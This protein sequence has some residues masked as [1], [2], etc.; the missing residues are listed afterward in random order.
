MCYSL[1]GNVFHT[2]TYPGILNVSIS[3]SMQVATEQVFVANLSTTIIVT[4][5]TPF[6]S[7]VVYITAFNSVGNVMSNGTSFTTGESG[8]KYKFHNANLQLFLLV[9]NSIDS[10]EAIEI[11]SRSLTLSW[12]PPSISN[13]ILVHYIIMQNSSEIDHTFPN[14]T[15]LEVINLFP[16]TTYQFTVVACTS[17]GCTESPSEFIKTME[18]GKYYDHNNFN[19]DIFTVMN[20]LITLDNVKIGNL[21]RKNRSHKKYLNKMKILVTC[22]FYYI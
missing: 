1:F 13:G 2:K 15:I 22:K 14:T 12:E 11:Q 17:I 7:Y 8:M 5:L 21:K 9:P 20:L 18:A 3:L 4:N 10:P 16:F 6:T 19:K